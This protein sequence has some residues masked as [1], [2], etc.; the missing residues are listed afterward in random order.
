LLH[1]TETTDNNDMNTQ[2]HIHKPTLAH[3]WNELKNDVNTQ[4]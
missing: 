4:R 1:E 3:L 2:S